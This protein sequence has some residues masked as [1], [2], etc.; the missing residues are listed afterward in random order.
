MS[1]LESTNFSGTDANNNAA[2][3]NGFPEGMLPGG[4]ND[5]ARAFMGAAKRQFDRTSFTLTSAGTSAALTLTPSPA[6]AGLLNGQMYGFITGT[7]CIASA[8]L[9]VNAKGAKKLR[10]LTAAGTFADVAASDFPAGAYLTV[11]YNLSADAYIIVG[12]LSSNVGVSGPFTPAMTFGGGSTGLT[13]TTQEGNYYKIGNLV[14]FDLSIVINAKGSSTGQAI[15]TGLPF[16]ASA[17]VTLAPVNFLVGGGGGMVSLVAGGGVLA[18]IDAS[19]STITL[20]LQT[21]TTK[22]NMTHANFN[23]GSVFTISGCY[24]V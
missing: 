8:T 7:T 5:A 6:I 23:N 2:V 19:A 16:A 9:N 24:L 10:K 4:V 20:W 12:P 17:S 11:V 18:L 21:T 3:P 22:A 14:F 1:D 15:V 13:F